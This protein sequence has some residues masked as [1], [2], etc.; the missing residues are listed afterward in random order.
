MEQCRLSR[1]AA[2]TTEPVHALGLKAAL[3]GSTLEMVGVLSD[4]DRFGVFLDQYNPDILVW[5]CGSEN[6]GLFQI[7]RQIRVTHPNCHVVVWI[8]SPSRRFAMDLLLLGVKA[9]LSKT[10][11][12]PMVTEC[13]E[14]VAAGGTWLEPELQALLQEMSQP[15][16]SRREA[17]LVHLVAAGLANKEIATELCITEGTVKVYLSKL[18][19]KLNV[20][21][22]LDLAMYGVRNFGLALA[23]RTSYRQSSGTA[24]ARRAYAAAG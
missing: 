18:F 17:Q 7:L 20:P 1:L 6:S 11:A 8:L 21:D 14:K 19:R 10:A 5:D 2:F 16:L 24:P 22:R 13:L 9:I 23:D 15:R 12:I 4:Q 3:E